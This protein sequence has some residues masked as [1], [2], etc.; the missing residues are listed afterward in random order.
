MMKTKLHALT[1]IDA[2]LAVLAA[3]AGLALYIRT[4]APGLLLGDSGEF[5][6]LAYTLGMT[7]PTGYPLYILLAR[8]FTLL[9]LGDLAWRVNLFSAVLA[10]ATLAC[11]YLIVQL[12][13]GRRL[14]SLSAA[15]S[16]A[17]MPLFWFYAVIAELYIPASFLTALI[18]LFLLLWRQQERPWML[19]VT[20]LLG[21]L[22]LAVHSTVALAAPAIGVYLLT[23]GKIKKAWRPALAG[24]L[25]GLVLSL[26]AF[27]VIDRM[28]TPGTYY[29]A[30]VR[31]ALSAWK[32]TETDFES[33]AERLE[34]LYTGRQFNALMFRDPQSVMP[35]HWNAYIE[36]LQASAAP[37]TLA[38]IALGILMLF[39]MNWREALLFLLAGG[40]QTL[41]A[42]NY[43]VDDFYV[44]FIPSF[45]FLAL[46]A[47]VGLGR[48]LDGLQWL[49]IRFLGDRRTVRAAAGLAGMIVL[50]LIGQNWAEI[51][52][53]AWRDRQVTF[54]IGTPLD[55]YPYPIEDPFWVQEEAASLVNALE[56]DAIVFTGWDML[57]PY[58]FVAHL[59]QGRTQMR[60]H[61]TYPQEG[62][63]GLA[64]S[65]VI[66][67]TGSL[68]RPVYFTERPYGTATLQLKPVVKNGI[69]LYQVVGV[70]P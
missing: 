70:K 65:T 21:G 7:H 56:P 41:F 52:I 3:L 63:S 55:E 18:V 49:L 9:P 25:S 17:V 46:W 19:F 58:Y 59:E 42:L 64:D 26:A 8:V 35:V 40:L 10:A 68:P 22:S 47:G 1:R 5:Q 44:F 32:M 4:L 43:A 57:Y 24:A 38:A 51:L 39:A 37:F 67:I 69:Q 11:V 60:F 31:H 2:I 6:T 45:V 30:T 28:N 16:L 50:V 66:Y 14:A 34:F 15:F 20:G 53:T 61:E 33:P 23:S 48:V 62:M 54:A 13:V 36:I 29:D 27:F 12:L